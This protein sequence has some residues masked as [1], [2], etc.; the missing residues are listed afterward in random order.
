MK[1][2]NDQLCE[3][4]GGRSH[5]IL[6][7][8]VVK[9]D[10]W[11]ADHWVF[12]CPVCQYIYGKGFAENDLT[13]Y[14]RFGGRFYELKKGYQVNAATIQSSVSYIKARIGPGKEWQVLLIGEIAYQLAVQNE[15]IRAQNQYLQKLIDLQTPKP[16]IK[17]EEESLVDIDRGE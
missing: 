16:T 5:I 12:L 6:D 8:R 15:Q 1:P 7:S 17:V 11:P 2:G 3:G 10:Q 4:C 9:T 14:E 13:V